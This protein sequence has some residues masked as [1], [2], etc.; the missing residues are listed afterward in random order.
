MGM[1]LAKAEQVGVAVFA[2][3]P[4]AGLAKTR[5]IPRLGA[6]GA[7]DLQRR[8]IE[9]ALAT[10]LAAKVG[11]V[12]LWCA[13]DVK[14]ETFVSLAANRPIDLHEQ[15]G[16]DLGARMLHAFETL[17]PNFPLLLVGTDCP[18][19]TPAHLVE[20]AA[21]LRRS[22]DAVFLPTE[23]GGYAL[24]GLCKP[25]PTLFDEMPWG[26]ERVM[27]ET[28]TRAQ[29]AALCIAEPIMVWD[30]DEPADYDR[31]RSLKLV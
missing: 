29:R 22:A 19:L 12:S 18:V 16:G 15:T 6:E 28:R 27:A 26:T 3:A 23:D 14:H 7:A 13:P 24:V 20:C 2:K 9:R 11:P 31:A 8:L 10:A 4:V 25:V 5:L 17:T 21:I 1:R 30:L